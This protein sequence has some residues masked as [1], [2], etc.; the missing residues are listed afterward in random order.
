M[1]SAL[2]LH[3]LFISWYCHLKI[4]I[5]ALYLYETWL[6]FVL[7]SHEIFI[8]AFNLHEIFI[9]ALYLHETFI[10]TLAL[11]NICAQPYLN[12]DICGL[13]SPN[14]DICALASRKNRC[15]RFTYKE[16]WLHEIWLISSSCIY[17]F[18]LVIYL[19]N[20]ST[21]YVNLYKFS[22]SNLHFNI[23]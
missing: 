8:F 11:R 9:S 23:K 16:Y 20:L 21:R 7:Y 4:L 10:S 3:A 19:F 17:C 13:L 14:I 6:I 15:L 5:S 1:I 18:H 22:Q 12:I 2:Y